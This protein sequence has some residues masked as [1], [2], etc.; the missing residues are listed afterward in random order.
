MTITSY[1][2]IGMLV[3]VRMLSL[4]SIT[5]LFGAVQVPNLF[6]IGFAFFLAELVM[7]TMTTAQLARHLTVLDTGHFIYY[8]VQEA[9]VGFAIGLVVTALFA[10]VQFAGELLDIQTGFSVATLLAPGMIAPAGILSNFYYIMF[11]MIFIG[12]DGLSTVVLA[13]LNS[14]RYLPLGVTVF[15]GSVANVLLQLLINLTIIGV[16]LAAPVLLATFMTNVALALAS[17]LVPQ[18]NVFVVGFP[19]VLLLGLLLLGIV[20]SALVYVMSNMVGSLDNQI[21]SMLNAMGGMTP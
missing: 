12:G 2:M 7:A 10:A 16:Q 13:L 18:M 20:M 1:I 21:A 11:V 5:P 19:L 6:K 8:V 17:R 4:F 14:F 3:F 15:D 9:M